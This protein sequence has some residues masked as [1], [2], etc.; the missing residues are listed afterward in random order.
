MFD[1]LTLNWH[2]VVAIVVG[3]YELIARLIPTVSDITILGK[4][5][6]FLKWMSDNLNNLKK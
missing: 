3:V 2:V 5:I 6:G 1:W 4:I